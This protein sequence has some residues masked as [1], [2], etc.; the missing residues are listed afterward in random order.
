MVDEYAPLGANSSTRVTT[1]NAPSVPR[2]VAPLSRLP[3]LPEVGFRSPSEVGRRAS[4]PLTFRPTS[5]TGRLVPVLL[6]LQQAYGRPNHLVRAPKPAGG[7]ALIDERLDLRRKRHVPRL[8][9]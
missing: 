3:H 7:D 8:D 1:S 4:P 5:W 9:I 2:N 6:I